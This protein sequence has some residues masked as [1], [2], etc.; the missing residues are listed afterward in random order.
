QVWDARSHQL[1]QHY[2]AHDGE[3]TSI[4]FHESGN[5]LLSSSTDASGREWGSRSTVSCAARDEA[6]MPSRS[7]TSF[8]SAF[9]RESLLLCLCAGGAKKGWAG[10]SPL[11]TATYLGSVSRGSSPI[12]DLREGRLVY[13]LKGHSGSVTACA[14]SADGTRFASGGE[15]GLVMSWRSHLD[16]RLAG[17][18]G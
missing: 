3:V 5:F 8:S 13:T 15:D 2:P 11:L 12:W 6:S 14:F 7:I 18:N 16:N 17:G 4:S 10:G 1:L 9:V